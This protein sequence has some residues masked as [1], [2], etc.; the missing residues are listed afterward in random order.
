MDFEKKYWSNNEFKLNGNPYSGYVGIYQNNAYVYDTEELLE[1]NNTY[2][3]RINLSNSYFDRVLSDKLELPYKKEDIVFAANDFLYSS[4]VKT[5]VDRLQKNN[6]YIFQNAIVTNSILPV[7]NNISIFASKDYNEYYFVYTDE[8]GE[9]KISSKDAV[10]CEDKVFE[11]EK[12]VGTI[13]YAINENCISGIDKNNILIITDNKTAAEIYENH[14]NGKNTANYYIPQIEIKNFIDEGVLKRYSFNEKGLTTK[15]QLD[16]TFY[17]Q[18]KFKESIGVKSISAIWEDR[19]SANTEYKQNEDRDPA[20]LKFDYT[21]LGN[22]STREIYNL[23]N[24]IDPENDIDSEDIKSISSWLAKAQVGAE[25]KLNKSTRY[26]DHLLGEFNSDGHDIDADEYIDIHI[27]YQDLIDIWTGHRKSYY[28]WDKDESLAL[29]TFNL[30]INKLSFILK[31]EGEAPN[32]TITTENEETYKNFKKV[33]STY[34]GNGFYLVTYYSNSLNVKPRYISNIGR[35]DEANPYWAFSMR[36]DKKIKAICDN[37]EVLKYFL[38]LDLGTV[39]SPVKNY[40]KV[41]LIEKKRNYTWRWVDSGSDEPYK[42]NTEK[43]PTLTYGYLKESPQWLNAVAPELVYY[44]E[45]EAV[46]EDENGVKHGI[47]LFNNNKIV[48]YTPTDNMTAE[49]CY[50]FMTNNIRS[51]RNFPHINQE[52]QYNFISSKGKAIEQKDDE[53]PSMDEVKWVENSEYKKCLYNPETYAFYV[54]DETGEEKIIKTY[55]TA[56]A[57]YNE[58]NDENG[59]NNKKYFDKVPTFKIITSSE[60]DGTPLHNFNELT[61]AEM[62]IRNVVD[63]KKG[64]YAD[65]LLFLMFKT[66]IL[67]IPIKHYIDEESGLNFNLDTEINLNDSKE[68]I[69]L[70]AVDHTNNNSLKFL[71]LTDI[72]VHKNMLY[73][74]DGGLNMVLR[75][76]IDYLIDPQEPLSFNINSIKLLDVLQGDGDINDKIYFNNPFSVD[77]CDDAVY[78]VDRGN[79][80]VKVY[81]PSLNYIKLLKNGYYANHDIQ[82]VA[83]NPYKVTLNNGTK[84]AKDSVWIF[85]VLGTSLF[86]SI[87]VGNEVVSYGKIQDIK[88]LSSRYSWTEE[89]KNIKFSASNSNYYYIA[90]TKRV[91]KLH[92]SNPYLPIGALSY[93]NQR[94]LISTMV[95]GR[96]HYRWTKLPRIYS[97]FGGDTGVTDEITWGY[98]PPMSSAEILDNR[99]FTLCGV[100]WADKQFNGDLIFHLGTLYDDNKVTRYIKAN[101]YKFD[102]NMTFYDIPTAD[103]VPMIK[104][105]NMAFYIEPDSF[106][107]SINNVDINI[108]DNIISNKSQDDYINAL[109]FNKLIYSVIHNLLSIKN[110][111]IGVFKAATSI[112]G[113]IVY[114]NMLLSDYFKNLEIDKESNYFVHNNEQMSIII[115][116]V[117]ENIYDI[118]KKIIAKMQTRFMAAQS[119]VNNTSRII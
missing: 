27:E 61:N 78:I 88:M 83:V 29:E 37:K 108:H 62:V 110:Q 49:D 68:Y 48:S 33:V 109:T 46:Q 119:Y 64:K 30:Q 79:K 15:T 38:A 52:V 84:L 19:L 45:D 112:E 23:I 8:L 74:C 18:L 17:P 102:G 12:L 6:D 80:C 59:I 53:L 67:I 113:I 65:V 10:C 72:K 76:D 44:T 94:S 54:D 71:N 98:K 5:I 96:M 42:V 31:F 41:P 115:N 107:S 111:L 24:N 103:L 1:K 101:N 25:T 86:L 16:T 90:T 91:Y 105:F 85:S 77:A 56:E 36:F 57:A 87:I 116:R 51:Y 32:L 93:F 11:G 118:Q 43:L 14:Y 114:D 47:V 22:K 89:I 75:Y 55:K 20:S 66:K 39:E 69:E 82:A 100:D 73:V 7:N 13:N 99:C 4:T 58:L 97:T 60:A 95:W 40:K 34:M 28:N 106:I 104:A 3:S 81:S 35:E 92:V 70:N 26:Y 117:F 63:D 9:I 21:L 50:I 2:I